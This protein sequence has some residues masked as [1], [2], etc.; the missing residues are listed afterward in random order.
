VH[1][2]R[3]RRKLSLYGAILEGNRA[4]WKGQMKSTPFCEALISVCSPLLAKRA[5]YHLLFPLGYGGF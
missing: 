5:Q 1:R 4:A 2:R 3:R